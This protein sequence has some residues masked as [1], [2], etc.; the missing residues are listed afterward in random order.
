MTKCRW[1]SQNSCE[2]L[3]G[4]ES[5]GGARPIG[6]VIAVGL[7]VA[8]SLFGDQAMYVILPVRYTE[9]GLSAVQVGILLSVNRWIRLLTNQIAERLLRGRAARPLFAAALLTGS[10][11]TAG[12]AFAPSFLLLLFLRMAWGACWSII[13]HTGVMV[14]IGI[15]GTGREGRLMG[16]YIGLVQVGFVAGNGLAGLFF[17]AAGF[18]TTFLL[19]AALSLAAVPMALVGRKRSQRS[20]SRPASTWRSPRGGMFS[21]TVRGF[22]VSLVGAGLIMSTLGYLL[23]AQFG[24]SV[25]IGPVVLGIATVNGLLLAAQ[26]VIN[27][28]GSPLFGGVIDKRG[29]LPAQYVGFGVAG[30]SLLAAGLLHGSTLLVPLV[31]VFFV[32]SAVSRLA[33]EAQA[34]AAGP[35]AY[36][37]FATATDL[38]SAAGPMLGWIGIEVAQSGLVFWAGGGLF[39]AGAVVALIAARTGAGNPTP[40]AEQ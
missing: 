28:V 20:H 37:S 27:G 31:L 38:G 15:A 33:A 5:G 32:M 29:L 25:P 2:K 19:A 35:K 7:A 12:Y 10:L 26:H 16:V 8:L 9:L 30:I 18:Q 21:L 39:L 3:T 11:L 22:I 23:K 4:N 24:E 36:A 14:T 17:D 13:R 6:A 40:E 34:A 1:I